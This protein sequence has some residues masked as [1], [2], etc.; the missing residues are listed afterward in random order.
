MTTGRHNGWSSSKIVTLFQY[1][2]ILLS[3]KVGT[4][5]KGQQ[6]KQDDNK[7]IDD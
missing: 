4:N 5:N 3:A 2:I 7:P 6:I 1:P